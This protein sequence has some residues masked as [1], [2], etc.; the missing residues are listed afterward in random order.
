[1]FIDIHSLQN[2][3]NEILEGEIS[4]FYPLPHDTYINQSFHGASMYSNDTERLNV[5]SFI[6]SVNDA[7]KRIR[8]E[9]HE[10]IVK[11]IYA[12]LYSSNK[13]VFDYLDYCFYDDNFYN[14]LYNI[15]HKVDI[16]K[17]LCYDYESINKIIHSLESPRFVFLDINQKEKKR[18]RYSLFKFLDESQKLGTLIIRM[19]VNF[20]LIDTGYF[21]SLLFEEKDNKGKNI[22]TYLTDK[23]CGLKSKIEDHKKKF[24]TSD[25]FQIIQRDL[26]LFEEEETFASFM[27]FFKLKNQIRTEE[28]GLQFFDKE[29]N[30]SF[31]E[32]LEFIR[33]FQE[34]LERDYSIKGEEYLT[35]IQKMPDLSR[36]YN[37]GKIQLLQKFYKREHILNIL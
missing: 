24:Y 29:R 22:E 32:E 30:L 14:N 2:Q 31:G 6:F 27:G 19:K 35:I 33:K 37:N 15:T 17:N 25:R 28:G 3:I 23:I 10:L 11:S 4:G 12:S 21:H 36:A 8:K 1:M 20:V 26:F 9:Q 18:I 16:V 5:T 34:N 7:F 13:K